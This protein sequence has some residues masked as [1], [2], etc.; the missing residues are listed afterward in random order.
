M[1]MGLFGWESKY[2]TFMSVLELGF[3]SHFFVVVF[4]CQ[5]RFGK[6]LEKN[7]TLGIWDC[8]WLNE[9][10]KVLYDPVIIIEVFIFSM[11]S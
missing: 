3:F 5:F 8:H 9:I 11:S 2:I 4:V 1:M 6:V 7:H 10:L